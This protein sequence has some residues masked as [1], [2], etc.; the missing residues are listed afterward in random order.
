MSELERPGILPCQS[1]DALI[2]EGAIAAETAFE[3]DQVQPASLDLRLG[4]RVWRVRASFL[5]GEG[6]K[7]AGRIAE[8]A[9][10]ELDLIKGAVLE[11]GCVYIAELQERLALPPGV[12]ARANPK[13]STGRVDVFVRLLSDGGAFDDVVEGYHGPTYIEIAP[14]TFSVL[15][16]R[17]T[18]LNQ[19]RLKRGAPQRL[20]VESVGVDLSDGIAGFRARR[21]APVV[22]LDRE[23][24]H[25]PRHY[26]EPLVPRDGQL[27]LDPGEFYILASKQAV[28]I[29]VEEAAEMTPIDPS[30]GEFRVHY[31]GFFDPGFGTDEAHGKGS[32]GVLEVRSHETPFI[33]ED[34]QTVARL[35]YEPLTDRPTRLYGDLGSHYQRQGLKLS[36]HFRA[37]GD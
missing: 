22:D 11:R 30:V 12:S 18:R 24:G 8:V 13:S 15:V 17:G 31:A 20:R 23:D 21:H 14:Q 19:L 29:P 4:A 16:R 5:P 9:M 10:H 1:I 26:W 34:G 33:L 3:P 27:L 25:D 35:V 37:W 7:V 28:E 32:R 2:A 6:R 36:K